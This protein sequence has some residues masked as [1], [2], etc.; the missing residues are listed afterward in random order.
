MWCAIQIVDNYWAFKYN[1]F[2]DVQYS[3]KLKRM[4]ISM[5]KMSA[6]IVLIMI[7]SLTGC[8]NNNNDKNIVFLNELI[9]CN[10]IESGNQFGF[11]LLY[12]YKGKKPSIE[13]VAFDD[14]NVNNMFEEMIDDTFDTIKNKKYKGYKAVILGFTF[15][16]SAMESGSNLSIQEARFNVNGKDRSIKFSDPLKLQKVSG[17]DERYLCNSVYSTNIPTVVFSNCKDI[18]NISFNYHSDQALTID[19]FEF[20]E[21]IDINNYSVYINDRDLGNIKDLF[22]LDVPANSEIRIDIGGE[23]ING[24]SFSDYYLESLLYYHSPEDGNK[25]LKNFMAI[26]AVGNFDDLSKLIDNKFPE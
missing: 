7:V 11:N 21:Y 18:E 1:A 4:I 24:D 15:D 25:V 19:K 2:M 10:I 6:L 14:N 13:F 17:G 23:F 22:P 5:K 16:I 26:Q 8:S 20:N 3:K 12:L 9:H